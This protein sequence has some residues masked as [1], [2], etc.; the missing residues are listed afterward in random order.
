MPQDDW[1]QNSLLLEHIQ[2]I[3]VWVQSLLPADIAQ[4]IQF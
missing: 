2:K 3:A 4:Y 1:W